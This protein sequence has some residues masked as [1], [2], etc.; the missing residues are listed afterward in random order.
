MRT[1]GSTIVGQTFDS[2]VFCLIAFL[3]TMGSAD[4]FAL[5]FSNIVFKVAIEALFTP[6]T[7]KVIA[8]MKKEA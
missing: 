1:I 8:L 3:G 5:A 7:Y 6:V 4:L 2:T